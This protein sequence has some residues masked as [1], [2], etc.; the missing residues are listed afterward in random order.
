[1]SLRIVHYNEPILR[2]KGEKIAEFNAA[3]ATLAAEMVETMHAAAGIGLAAQQ[4]GRAI[5]LCVVDLREVEAP[6]AWKLDGAKPPLELFMPLAVANP[7]ISVARGTAEVVDEE[8]CLS[9]PK[10]RGDIARPDAITV[11]FQDERGVPHTLV[12]D[13]LLAR[14][15]QHE[16][17][18]LNGVLF[19]DRM[20]KSVRTDLDETIRSLAKETKTAKKESS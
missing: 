17:D 6:F 1:M 14:C 11:K 18:H 13:G 5:Q 4:I 7:L 12:C 16:A 8:G 20:D 3:L 15:I 9:F 19:I 10:I 2:K